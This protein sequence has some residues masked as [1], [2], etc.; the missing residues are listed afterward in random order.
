[1]KELVDSG[2]AAGLYLKQKHSIRKVQRFG[3]T[4]GSGSLTASR[5]SI[6]ARAML[7]IKL[8]NYRMIIIH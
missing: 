7:S 5:H 3:D 6:V 2:E 4:E 8:P 1:M